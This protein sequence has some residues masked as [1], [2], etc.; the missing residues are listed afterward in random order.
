MASTPGPL[1][2]GNVIGE[3]KSQLQGM[4]FTVTI[5]GQPSQQVHPTG[6]MVEQMSN[7]LGTAIFNI[8]KQQ[9]LIN[10]QTAVTVSTPAG[11]GAGTGLGTGVVE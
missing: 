4:T 3:V 10:V 5:P 11:P 2:I 7:A 9:L 1:D 6:P 8:L